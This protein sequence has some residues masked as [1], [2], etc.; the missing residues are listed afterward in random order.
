MRRQWINGLLLALM[1]AGCGSNGKNPVD[2][3]PA[4]QN[5]T[6]NDSSIVPQDASVVDGPT[7]PPIDAVPSV[8]CDE[9]AMGEDYCIRNSP[10]GNPTP[11]ARQLPVPYQSC[12]L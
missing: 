5:D 2:T 11:V 6:S 4:Q 9:D 7:A 8:S 10:G 12:K 3:A 1:L